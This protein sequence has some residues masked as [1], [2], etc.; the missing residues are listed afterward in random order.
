MEMV[1]AASPH[2]LDLRSVD[3]RLTIRVVGRYGPGVPGP[4]DDLKVELTAEAGPFTMATPDIITRD[5]LVD[6]ATCLDQL[7]SGET[8]VWRD[9][10]RTLALVFAPLD[11][12]F[13][14]T[15]TDEPG[16]GAELV[17]PVY[18]DDSSWIDEQRELL[19]DIETQFPAESIE[20]SPGVWTWARR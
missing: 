14:V 5:E 11:G 15:I 20:S 18:P 4:H 8:A 1:D 12:G 6:W 10:G 17:L 3:C 19:H 7:A 2:L 16:S 9:S 13:Q